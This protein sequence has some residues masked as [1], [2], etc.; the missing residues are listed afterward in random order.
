MNLY[1]TIEELHRAWGAS[2]TS[3]LRWCKLGL[4]D[5]RQISSNGATRWVIYSPSLNGFIPPSQGRPSLGALRARQNKHFTPHHW[6]DYA[7]ASCAGNPQPIQHSTCPTC[8]RILEQ[9]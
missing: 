6:R 3:I 5:A 1:V 9:P 8:G 2:R 7:H 4:I